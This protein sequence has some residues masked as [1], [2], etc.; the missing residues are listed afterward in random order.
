VASEQVERVR[1]LFE[2]GRAAWAAGQPAP[3]EAYAGF[4]ED[5]DYDPVPNYPEVR[6]IR[7]LANFKAW[8]GEM[9]ADWGGVDLELTSIEEHG[10]TVIARVA[11]RA[12]GTDTRPPLEGR[13][14]GVFT[15]RD[16]KIVREQD[17]LSAVE[18]RRAADVLN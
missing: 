3:E 8:M 18:A 17:F 10:E 16:G 12:T 2:I 14:F 4:A 13:V 1:R 6:H 7:G 11:M 9:V 15:F 5:F